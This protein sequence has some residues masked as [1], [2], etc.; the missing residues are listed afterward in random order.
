MIFKTSRIWA[1]TAAMIA[2]GSAIAQE[3]SSNRVAANTDW[4]GVQGDSRAYG[5][6]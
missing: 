4:Q 6:L 3:D 1:M 2:G 5:D